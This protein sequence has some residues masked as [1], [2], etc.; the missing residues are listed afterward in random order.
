MSSSSVLPCCPPGLSRCCF[1]LLE[2][3]PSAASV[4]ERKAWQRRSLE[5]VS[6]YRFALGA[7]LLLL[8]D[9]SLWQKRGAD[10][11]LEKVKS[12]QGESSPD[13]LQPSALPWITACFSFFLKVAAA[14]FVRGAVEKPFY[15][16][17]FTSI[18]SI[19]DVPRWYSDFTGKADLERLRFAS[20]QVCHCGFRG[21]R[22]QPGVW[23]IH[24]NNIPCEIL[25]IVCFPFPVFSWGRDLGR[26][27]QHWVSCIKTQPVVLAS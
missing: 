8:W 14:T 23:K 13:V 24:I 22:C 27:V 21:P 9:D 1:L 11:R 17:I 3:T 10:S 16:R 6:S 25:C 15:L 20:P 18:Y 12:F 5:A 2:A 7:P 26:L 19:E 4:A